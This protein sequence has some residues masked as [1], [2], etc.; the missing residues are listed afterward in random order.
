MN[1]I[2][3]DVSKIAVLRANAIGDFIFTLPALEAL[4]TAYP[5]AEIVLLGQ[6][7]H[8]DFLKNRPGPV[9]RVEVIPVYHG[10]GA[11]HDALEDPSEI[12]A[13]FERMQA[14]SFDIAI[15]VYG[16]GRFSN[17]FIKSLG[18]RIT[19]G[20]KAEDAEP[21]DLWVP[22]LHYQHE[23]M[24][25][26]EVVALIG[27]VRLKEGQSLP[28]P[29]LQV[30]SA[31]LEEA[32]R[33]LPDNHSPFVVFHVGAGDPR[34][35]WPVDKFAEVG[36][37]LAGEGFEVFVSGIEGERRA[38]EGVV[39]AMRYQAHNICNVMS[40]N[41]LA[42]LLSRAQLLVSN[43]SGPLHLAAA[44]GTATVGIFWCGNL[45]MAAPLTRT[46][47]RQLVSWQLNCPACGLD[48]TRQECEHRESFVAGIS[49]EEVIQ[50]ARDLI[51]MK[52]GSQDYAR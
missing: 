9:D 40:L 32:S 19:V 12:Q 28:E 22:Y 7:W 10:V 2:I 30:T 38:V 21:L 37:A 29:R 13:F 20:L 11:E 3:P 52:E 48:H 6:D 39:A 4:R 47:H 43:D 44:I 46:R 14:E 25:Y 16:G 26:L 42:G 23:V 50:S 45:I 8:A 1:G 41:G 51:Y 27:A 33:F 15:Q 36:D 18:A 17:P 31:D 35:R 24:R 5:D 49:S 34:R